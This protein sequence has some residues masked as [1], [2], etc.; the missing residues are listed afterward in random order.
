[1]KGHAITATQ[2]IT[3]TWGS[4]ESCRPASDEIVGSGGNAQ[5]LLSLGIR[6]TNSTGAIGSD[7]GITGTIE[8]IVGTSTAGAPPIGKAITPSAAWQTIT[9]T[10][11]VDPVTRFTGDGVITSTTGK[12]VMEELG[13]HDRS[14]GTGRRSVH[15]VYR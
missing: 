5:I 2:T 15:A 9:F 4:L 14:D 1:M 7:G 12:A 8:W 13:D 11:G 6:E 3:T 10:P